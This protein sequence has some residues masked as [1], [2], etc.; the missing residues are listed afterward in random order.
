MTTRIRIVGLLV[1]SAFVLVGCGSGSD[2][3]VAD[4]SANKILAK[5]K[6][7]LDKQDNLTVKGKGKEEGSSS[8]IEVDMSFA[9]ASASGNVEFNG[10]K[11]E[12]IK[13]DGKSYFK[14]DKSFFE[15]AGAPNAMLDA[16]AGKWVLIDDNNQSFAEIGS[17]VSKDEFVDDLLKPEGKI[18]KGKEKKVNGVDCVSLKSKKGTLYV[19]KKDGKPISIVTTEDGEGTIN[20]TYDKVDSVEAP[21]SDEVVDLNKLAAGS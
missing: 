14:A 10:M 4:L 5:A 1:V 20:F 17:F 13:A 19:D 18:T 7:Q 6:K 16:I 21:S 8:D 12:V 3:G 2:D 15:S 9:G 11:L